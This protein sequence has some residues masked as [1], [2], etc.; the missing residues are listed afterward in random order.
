MFKILTATRLYD[1]YPSLTAKRVA[2]T[3]SEDIDLCPSLVYNFGLRSY[4]ANSP[5][6]RDCVRSCPI[7]FRCTRFLTGVARLVWRSE[8]HDDL[9]PLGAS[10][11]PFEVENLKWRLGNRCD[12]QACDYRGRDCS[13]HECAVSLFWNTGT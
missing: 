3:T 13:L 8:S 4:H 7:R 10:F 6:Y 1:F 2:L 9:H 11:D 5:L 12:N